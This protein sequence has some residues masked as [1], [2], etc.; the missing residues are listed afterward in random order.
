MVIKLWVPVN[1]QAN[2]TFL[3]PCFLTDSSQLLYWRKILLFP[4]TGFIT[5]FS[6]GG[7][8]RFFVKIPQCG[9]YCL[10]SNFFTIKR[11][12]VCLQLSHNGEG[13]CFITTFPHRGGYCF[14]YSFL[15][16]ERYWFYFNFSRSGKYCL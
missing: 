1:L 13:T 7:G 3:P 14:Y 12:M 4:R 6:Q 9:G 5:T 8:Y 10:C 16:W 2:V 15:Q 11:D